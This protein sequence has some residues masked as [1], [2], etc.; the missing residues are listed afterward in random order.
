MRTKLIAVIAVSS[1]ALA[2]S[3]VEARG[4]GGGQAPM[5]GGYGNSGAQGQSGNMSQIRDQD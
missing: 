4:P 3:L 2:S 1:F 5:G